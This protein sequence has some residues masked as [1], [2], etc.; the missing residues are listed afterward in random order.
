S[1]RASGATNGGAMRFGSSGAEL[2]YPGGDG[3]IYDDFGANSWRITGAP[4]QALDQYHIYNVASTAGKWTSRINGILHYTTST[5]TVGFTSSPVIGVGGSYYF[6]GDVAEI[7]IYD[8]S[9][10]DSERANVLHFLDSKY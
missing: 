1:N 5:N 4:R 8:R 10:N 3:K 7:L 2:Y 9:L 6:S